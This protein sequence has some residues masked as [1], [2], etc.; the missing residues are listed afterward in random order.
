MHESQPDGNSTYPP[1]YPPI[2]PREECRI[3]TQQRKVPRGVQP[4]RPFHHNPPW[5]FVEQIVGHS[6]VCSRMSGQD[7]GLPAHLRQVG[8]SR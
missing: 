7:D 1:R 8:S 2:G 3:A 5:N 4:E 6:F